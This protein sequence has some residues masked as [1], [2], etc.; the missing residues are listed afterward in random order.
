MLWRESKQDVDMLETAIDDEGLAALVV[1]DLGEVSVKASPDCR[2]DELLAVLCREHDV[3]Q[4][5]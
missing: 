5:V 2:G 3:N 1:D 4:Q